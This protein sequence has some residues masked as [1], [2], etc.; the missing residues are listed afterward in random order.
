MM[1]LAIPWFILIY[2]MG[3]YENNIFLRWNFYLSSIIC[4]LP[5]LILNFMMTIYA[6]KEALYN[7]KHTKINNI[8]P[9]KSDIKK[10]N[11]RKIIKQ[12]KETLDFLKQYGLRT[13]KHKHNRYSIA[14][15]DVKR[16][17]EDLLKEFPKLYVI[18][19]EKPKG[20]LL[21]EIYNKQYD[22]LLI[23]VE[24]SNK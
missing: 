8:D 10:L 24:I 3:W 5:T 12:Q 16:V 21:L 6:I 15:A 9:L 13:T 18:S 14:A 20:T 7:K 2:F 11:A 19:T 23:Q 17:E 1:I 22:F 4:L